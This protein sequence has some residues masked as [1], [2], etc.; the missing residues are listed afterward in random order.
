MNLGVQSTSPVINNELASSG[1]GADFFCLE[2]AAQNRD[3]VPSI[4]SGYATSSDFEMVSGKTGRYA[5]VRDW[6]FL[7]L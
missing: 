2:G 5:Q 3:A 7:A 1:N 6:S 4:P